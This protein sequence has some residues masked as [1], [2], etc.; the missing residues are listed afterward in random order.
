M[1]LTILGRYSPYP[2][3]DGACPGYLVTSKGESLLLDCGSGVVARLQR[4]IEFAQLKVVILSHL[5]GDHCSDIQVLRYAIDQDI[6][7]QVDHPGITVYAPPEPDEEFRRLAYK[8]ALW[9][10]SL[11]DGQQFTVGPFRVRVQETDHPLTCFAVRIEDGQ[12]TLT[13][14]GD[15]AFFPQLA[16]FARGSDLLLAEASLSPT[17]EGFRGHMTGAQAGHLAEAARVKQLML[18]HFW[19]ASDPK[20]L[21][22]AASDMTAAPVWVAE[23]DQTYSV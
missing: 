2:P 22:N 18:T 17:E 8:K 21:A 16:E 7:S 3:A 11:T 15:T 10:R 1:K 5:H 20:S 23:E 9:A 4:H 6:R 14:T 13:Y 19:P 12:H